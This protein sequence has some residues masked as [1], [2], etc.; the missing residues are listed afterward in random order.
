MDV[1]GVLCGLWRERGKVQQGCERKHGPELRD[2]PR[3]DGETVSIGE[4]FAVFPPGGTEYSRSEDGESN[5]KV[6]RI[7]SLVVLDLGEPVGRIPI[8]LEAVAVDTDFAQT[9][10]PFHPDIGYQLTTDDFDRR[11]R[12]EKERT[13]HFRLTRKPECQPLLFRAFTAEAGLEH[14]GLLEIDPRRTARLRFREEVYYVIDRLQLSVEVN[15]ID[16]RAWADWQ[17]KQQ[18]HLVFADTFYPANTG[19]LA[20]PLAYQR[21]LREGL[22]L[23]FLPTDDLSTHVSGCFDLSAPRMQQPHRPA[24]E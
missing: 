5:S 14:L 18:G 12:L 2:R 19:P 13:P 7:R 8:S 1:I 9:F 15:G 21:T 3:T 20:V 6:T 10:T 4:R 22:P 11:R 16:F 23:A 17:A 24:S